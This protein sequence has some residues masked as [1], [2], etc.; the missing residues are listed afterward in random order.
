MSNFQKCVLVVL[1]LNFNDMSC[2]MNTVCRPDFSA[3]NARKNEF[4]PNIQS[5]ATA[6]NNEKSAKT[7]MEEVW[8]NA[9]NSGDITSA[10]SYFKASMRCDNYNPTARIFLLTIK[11]L[12]IIGVLSNDVVIYDYGGVNANVRKT[13]LETSN[14]HLELLFGTLSEFV[15]TN[16]NF[17]DDD[18]CNYL[19]ERIQ[20][21][22]KNDVSTT[23]M[24]RIVKHSKDEVEKT[25]PKKEAKINRIVEINESMSQDDSNKGNE[26][27]SMLQYNSGKRNE[28]ESLPMHIGSS[29]IEYSGSQEDRTNLEQDKQNEQQMMYISM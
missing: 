17:S 15:K 16:Q 1:C 13:I 29:Q 28:N 11:G 21:H 10:I 25:K 27:G 12:R 24:P 8:V 5:V 2:S 19:R 23:K 18:F 4:F 9:I 14:K 20:S 26:N 7:N 6:T 22:P 3:Y